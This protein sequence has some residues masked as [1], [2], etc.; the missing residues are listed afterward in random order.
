MLVLGIA[1]SLLWSVHYLLLAAP[2]GVAMNILGAGRG[3]LYRRMRPT[4]QN[5]WVLWLL[6]V[7]TMAATALTWQGAISLLALVGSSGTVIAY[8]QKKPK[9]IRRLAL[10]SSPFWLTYNALSGSYPGVV[11]EI[12]SITSN[13]LGQYRFDFK[14]ASRRKLLRAAKST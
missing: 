1:A 4:K 6:L 10:A 14:H 3:Y 5:R 7:V 9:H 11:A 2:T 8:W 13:L 12:F